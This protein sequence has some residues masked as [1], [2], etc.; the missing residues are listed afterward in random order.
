MKKLLLITLSTFLFSDALLIGGIESASAK[1]K[2]EACES[3]KTQAKENYN[4][5]DMN[6]GC[7]CEKSDA[8]EWMCFV[9]FEYL[10]KEK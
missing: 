2:A 5:Q 6:V 3:A 8:K 1:E 4:V 10:A 9:R 7:T